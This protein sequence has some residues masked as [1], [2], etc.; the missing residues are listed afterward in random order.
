MNER[1]AALLEVLLALTLTAAMAAALAAT[2]RFG[3]AATDRAQAAGAETEAAGRDRRRLAALWRGLTDATGGPTAVVWLGADADAPRWGLWRLEIAG[4]AAR[5]AP[6]AGEDPRAP[7]PCGAA[8]P[9]LLPATRLAY[10]GANGVL[11]PEWREG[12]P[13]L[14]ALEGAARLVVAPRAP[15]G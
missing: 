2:A 3:L 5:L 6:C 9:L 1:G 8:E 15:D 14:I 7:G 10:A 13:A 12:A 4:G 11:G